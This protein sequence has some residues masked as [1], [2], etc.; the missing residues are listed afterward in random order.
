M[1]ILGSWLGHDGATRKDEENRQATARAAAWKMMPDLRAKDVARRVKLK[2]WCQN[3]QG[4]LLFSSECWTVGWQTLRDV[5]SLENV[6]LTKACRWKKG[7]QSVAEWRRKS[8]AKLDKA[9]AEEKFQRMHVA[10]LQRI[11]N[12]AARLVV[13]T[14]LPPPLLLCRAVL[15]DRDALWWR[16][17]QAADTAHTREIGQR[18]SAR[19][20][21]WETIF[22]AEWALGTD[23]KDAMLL[24][25]QG[26][27]G[28]MKELHE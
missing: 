24:A 1:K 21:E 17:T 26:G 7:E 19:V 4:C 12:W 22:S 27:H 14:E 16:A 9:F 2:A 20:I 11:W 23:W 13:T 25:S 5:R 18:T 28:P 8:S 3:I 6:M 15:F 10:L